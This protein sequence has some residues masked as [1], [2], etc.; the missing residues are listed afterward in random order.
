[1][2]LGAEK[3]GEILILGCWESIP[4]KALSK[5]PRSLVKIQRRELGNTCLC[6]KNPAGDHQFRRNYVANRIEVPNAPFA[7]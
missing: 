6:L 2:Q 4:D 7:V 5:I 3:Y 1:M